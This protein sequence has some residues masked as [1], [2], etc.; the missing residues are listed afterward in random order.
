MSS[1]L[2]IKMNRISSRNRK[3]KKQP[4]IGLSYKKNNSHK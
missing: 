2:F 3:L 1:K 4:K